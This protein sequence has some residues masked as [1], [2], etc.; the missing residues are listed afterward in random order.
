MKLFSKF[1]HNRLSDDCVND[2]AEK[3]GDD[4]E[5]KYVKHSVTPTFNWNVTFDEDEYK[6]ALAHFSHLKFT[7]FHSH[8]YCISIIVLFNHRLLQFNNQS[9][10]YYSVKCIINTSAL[11]I[12]N[13]LLFCG[14]GEVS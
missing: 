3:F 4:H 7:V 14:V 10:M 1:H 9:F 6:Q 8:I 11:V 13:V 5:C 2:K 12:I